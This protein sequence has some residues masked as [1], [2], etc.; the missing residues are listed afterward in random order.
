MEPAGSQETLLGLIHTT[1]TKTMPTELL[2]AFIA[3]GIVPI[4]LM[5]LAAAVAYLWPPHQDPYANPD[6]W[7]SQDTDRREL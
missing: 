7:G 4:G 3:F 6:N 2:I 5:G 1:G